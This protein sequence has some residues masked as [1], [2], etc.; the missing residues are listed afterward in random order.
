MKKIATT[1]AAFVLS[2]GA[3]FAA[4]P[5]EG[6]WR[7][8]PDNNGNTGLIEVKVCGTT[9]CGVL[10]QAFDSNGAVMASDNIGKEIIFETVPHGNGRYS[11]KVFAPDSGKTY[12][13]KLVLDGDNLSV[14]GCVLGLC[15]NGGTWIRQ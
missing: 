6:M 7:T 3:A 12:S 11:G 9:F 10:T 13:S 1:I 2:A 14:S 4:D 15:R 5:I 8:V